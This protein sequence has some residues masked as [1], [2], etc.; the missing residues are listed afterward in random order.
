[1]LTPS[2]GDKH[3]MIFIESECSLK[4]KLSAVI[5][6]ISSVLKLK[7]LSLFVTRCVVF[8]HFDTASES[9]VRAGSLSKV[10]TKSKFKF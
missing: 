4:G 5:V 6:S 7:L 9:T 3:G 8:V 1:M 2:I 10:E